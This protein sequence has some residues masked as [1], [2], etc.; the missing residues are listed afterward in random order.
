MGKEAEPVER[1]R[2]LPGSLHGPCSSKPELSF[3]QVRSILQT[4]ATDLGY[5]QT[6]QGAG[7]ID[8]KNMVQVLR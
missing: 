4:T 6:Q 7:L 3:A 1:P 5:P 8:V 2:M